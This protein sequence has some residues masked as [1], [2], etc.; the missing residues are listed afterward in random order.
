MLSVCRNFF[1]RNPRLCC[2]LPLLARRRREGVV[3]NKRKG[4]A[5][6]CCARRNVAVCMFTRWADIKFNCLG[7]WMAGSALRDSVHTF[8]I[9]AGSEESSPQNASFAGCY[10]FVLDSQWKI[11]RIN[12]CKTNDDF[13]STHHALASSQRVKSKK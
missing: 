7:G 4:M 10:A 12:G 2:S 11:E 8:P 13:A 9:K 3:L 5:N 1:R 6:C